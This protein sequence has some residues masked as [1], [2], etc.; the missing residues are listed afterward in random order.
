MIGSDEIL[1]LFLRLKLGVVGIFICFLTSGLDLG[2]FWRRKVLRALK[3]LSSF[4]L[5]IG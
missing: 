3:C 4:V 2:N 1:F 5:F